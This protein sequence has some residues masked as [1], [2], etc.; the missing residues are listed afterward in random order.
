ME[1]RKRLN[2]RGLLK[3]SA[4]TTMTLV[5]TFAMRT[6]AHARRY[7]RMHQRPNIVFIMADDMGFAD[8]SFNGQR[9]FET[10]NID[11]IARQ[12]VRLPRAYA[13]S[14]VCS[15]TRTALMT[16]R[17]QYRIPL[18]LEEPLAG[19][20]P[21]GVGLPPEL[22]TL[23]G[24]LRD[25]DYHTMLIGKWHLGELP[26]FGPLQSGYDHFF[27]FRQ[28]ALD[29]FSHLSRAGKPDLWD[30]DVQVDKVGYL[31]DLIGQN[32]V[33]AIDRFSRTDRPFFMSVHFNAPHWPW[34]GPEDEEESKRI[35]KSNLLH[36]DG[37]TKKTY[38][39]MIQAMDRQV[40][41]ILDTL[42]KKGLA[43]NTIVVFTSDNG[44]ERFADTWPFS[45][46][47]TE[48]LEGGL[49]VPTAISWPARLPKG[50]VCDQAMITM[51]WV[52]T[53][54]AAAGSRPAADQ[55][56]DGINLLP[57]LTGERTPAARKLFWRYKANNQRAMLDGDYKY[58]KIAENT[59]LFNV[60]TDPLERANLKMREPERYARLEAEWRDWNKTMLP[61][62]DASFTEGVTAS[63]QADHIGSKEVIKTADPG[64]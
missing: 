33:H 32:A 52:P 48:L 15:A 38:E 56:S 27:G 37:G 25:A 6:P 40:G 41:S 7:G 31:T 24:L 63:K 61:Q 50:K 26:H 4:A 28:G 35:K 5:G 59:Y 58:L 17:Y 1:L 54:L 46:Q 44:G 51:D 22:S 20:S 29:Y 2:R 55:P 8:V 43:K 23:P 47:K 36:T 18:G 64:D 34:E 11:R 49:R 9:D 19:S 3:A 30:Q 57:F 13:N 12:G 16:G 53:L 45:G 21:P 14:A 62:I 10:P 42:A 60:T 39:D